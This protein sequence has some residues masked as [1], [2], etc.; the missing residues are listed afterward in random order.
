MAPTRRKSRGSSAADAPSSAGKKR[1]QPDDSEEPEMVDQEPSKAKRAKEERHERAKKHIEALER[2][3]LEQQ[4]PAVVAALVQPRAAPLVRN[5]SHDKKKPTAAAA[6]SSSSKKKSLSSHAPVSS[7]SSSVA[8][9][10]VASARSVPTARAPVRP[11]AS[12][13]VASMKI[14]HVGPFKPKPDEIA[15]ADKLQAA[16]ARQAAQATIRPNAA[17]AHAVR[18]APFV[19]AKPNETAAVAAAASPAPAAQA[20]VRSNAAAQVSSPS[21]KLV[22]IGP[23][24]PKHT[25]TAMAVTLA[26]RSP[27]RLQQQQPIA[28]AASTNVAAA[29][30]TTKTAAAVAA[31]TSGKPWHK[32]SSHDHDK[33]VARPPRPARAD[34]DMVK[35]RR[36]QMHDDKDD[37]PEEHQDD[38]HGYETGD[39]SNHGGHQ[40][41]MS[42]HDDDDDDGYHTGDSD[43]EVLAQRMAEQKAKR[44]AAAAESQDEKDV[45]AD[46]QNGNDVDE[47]VDLDE[48]AKE[49]HTIGDRNHWWMFNF[50]GVPKVLRVMFF[51]LAPLLLFMLLLGW[52]SNTGILPMSSEP[53]VPCFENTVTDAA[54]L[55]WID[56]CKMAAEKNQLVP[57][58][59]AGI[60]AKGKLEA[61]GFD[62]SHVA[63]FVPK[64]N[65]MSCELSPAANVTVQAIH[66]RLQDMTVKHK[67][68]EHTTIPLD[69]DTLSGHDVFLFDYFDIGRIIDSAPSSDVS[70][71]VV[72][73][74]TLSWLEY[75]I[76]N[77]I[78]SNLVMKSRSDGAALIGLAPE[79]VQ[80]LSLPLKCVFQQA[81]VSGLFGI[82]NLL[83]NGVFANSWAFVGFV[84]EVLAGV[85]RQAP[86]LVAGFGSFFALAAYV[87]LGRRRRRSTN[88]AQLEADTDRAFQETLKYLTMTKVWH[89]ALT[90]RD[91]IKND[92]YPGDTTAQ[93]RFV[94]IVWPKVMRRM[95]DDERV[96]QRD[97]NANGTISTVW[98]WEASR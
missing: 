27:P 98:K 69:A 19:V 2:K 16:T 33:Q 24:N 81:I 44:A 50:A 63:M 83:V 52:I 61:C 12:A 82:K 74:D 91:T 7:A 32:N 89:K 40:Q 47:P 95:E 72:W 70:K 37:V 49:D 11:T 10:T 4:N 8:S 64:A 18:F 35:P 93:K 76:G 28:A 60:C 78:V 79:E 85:F 23:L 59:A 5:Q 36:H 88:P 15:I 56:R 42:A 66:D 75:A 94:S 67:C 90:I 87:V 80:N 86:A 31:W 62:Q 68:H 38:G 20:P 1:K 39:S 41:D 51:T 34:N 30:G 58:P 65:G 3:R 26:A 43:D 77:K 96:S 97:H 84:F 21:S 14:H 6:A 71:P 92:F 73:A 45:Y 54:S 57:C 55:D 53:S 13:H 22:S 46:V 48:Y 29:P 25:E 9:S 17:S